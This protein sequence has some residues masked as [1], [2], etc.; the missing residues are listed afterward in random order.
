MH[1]HAPHASIAS[2]IFVRVSGRLRSRLPVAMAGDRRRGRPLPGFAAAEEGL[3]RPVDD[4]HGPAL[5]IS[6][7]RGRP[8]VPAHDHKCRD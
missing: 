7:C 4:M 1:S 3:A 2:L 8:E 5:R 6:V